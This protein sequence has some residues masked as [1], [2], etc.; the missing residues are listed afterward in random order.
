[1][2]VFGQ[3]VH[4]QVQTQMA[5]TK[6]KCDFIVWTPQTFSVVTVLR[7]EAFIYNLIEKVTQFVLLHFIPELLH[8]KLRNEANV[9]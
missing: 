2:C 4:C 8:R 3:T 1:M 5:V 6:N 7:D 9:S